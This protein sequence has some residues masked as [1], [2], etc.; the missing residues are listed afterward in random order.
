MQAKSV[1]EC[2]ASRACQLQW[3]DGKCA[4]ANN[5][6]GC[7]CSPSSAP[8]APLPLRW[9][10][11]NLGDVEL[12]GWE[13]HRPLPATLSATRMVILELYPDIE[14]DVEASRMKLPLPI[15]GSMVARRGRQRF[16]ELLFA[17]ELASNAPGP[18]HVVAL[19]LAFDRARRHGL[20]SQLED[21]AAR[22][23]Q[24]V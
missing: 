22:N 17:I 9:S 21:Q 4:G 8:P 24:A 23:V 19:R 14:S 3:V 12:Q 16:D 6:V 7:G 5:H 2:L 15:P 1:L 13:I 20:S 11:R 18:V 10:P